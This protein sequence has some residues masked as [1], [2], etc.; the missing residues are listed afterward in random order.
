ME[1]QRI[2]LFAGLFFVSY[3][4]WVAWQEQFHPQAPAVGTTATTVVQDKATLPTGENSQL[5][6]GGD[7]NTQLPVTPTI[8]GETANTNELS[9]IA[10]STLLKSGKSIKVKTDTFAINIDL[11]EGDI[12]KV[13]LV[14]YPVEIDK[15]DVPFELL[16]DS[17]NLLFVAQSGFMAL[18]GNK[19]AALQVVPSAKSPYTTASSS[20]DMG[21]NDQLIVDLNWTSPEGVQIIKRFEFQ[22]DSYLI[23]VKH[24]VKNKSQKD[25]QGVL[26][27]RLLRGEPTQSNS[28]L[29]GTYSYTGGVIYSEEERYEKYNFSDMAD[30]DLSRDV[31][32][33]WIAMIQ[34]YFLGS[35]VPDS[36]T[37]Q[38]FYSTDLGQGRYY[39]GMN[40]GWVKVAKNTEQE[41]QSQ[42]YLGPKIQPVLESIAPGL[43]LTVDYTFLT[44]IAKPLY[45]ALHYIHKL[46]GNW[47]WAIIFLTILI[48]AIFYKLSE[49]QYKS[50][51]NMKRVQPRMAALKE[52]F[53]DDR[54]AYQKAMME[55]YKKEK[56]NPMG[57]CLP[58]LVQIPV[59]IAL[60]WVLLESVEMRQAPF[61]LWINDLSTKDPYYVLPV[62]M[63]LTMFLQQKLNPTMVDPIQAK[64]MMMLPFIFTVFFAFFPSGLVLYWV[65]NNSLSILQQQYITKIV[66]EKGAHGKADKSKKKK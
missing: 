58:M 18:P 57:G 39:L 24:I 33:G 51:A 9:K 26:R 20:Y 7:A 23:K 27:L 1:Q 34:H 53:G 41:I 4:L 30:E 3:L 12:R 61:M 16:N 21:A 48:K 36:K 5:P 52:R 44:V 35:W 17:G 66:L 55:L 22:R 43:E 47:G 14:K 11:L 2:L 60:Y 10:N 49:T 15:P 45:I 31:T 32:G 25:W 65:V 40:S 19:S 63:G 6:E 38:H 28:M 59:F 46:V 42:L 37:A 54:Q 56:F 62:L 29:T 13:D 50:M 64:V 8:P